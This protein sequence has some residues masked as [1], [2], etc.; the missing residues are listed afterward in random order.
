MR[1]LQSRRCARGS[2][3]PRDRAKPGTAWSAESWRYAIRQ[4]LA[5][6]GQPKAG[7]ARSGKAWH[8]VIARADKFSD[9]YEATTLL[10]FLRQHTI[11]TLA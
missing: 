3:F 10:V 4:S 9:R 5:L 7:A 2:L 6:R 8:C 11:P 1:C